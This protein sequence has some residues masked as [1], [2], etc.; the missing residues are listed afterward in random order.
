MRVSDT[1]SMRVSDTTF[2]ARLRHDSDARLRHDSQRGRG[3]GR[4]G[5]DSLDDADKRSGAYSNF[6][7]PTIILHAVS[8]DLK[9]RQHKTLGEQD[10]SPR[11]ATI[12]R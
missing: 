2:I 5:R 6:V 12:G 11:M 8:G 10:E 7:P 3:R 9:P 4:T 1:T